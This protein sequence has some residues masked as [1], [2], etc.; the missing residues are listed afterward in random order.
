[1]PTAESQLALANASR[2]SGD[3]LLI[4]GF[5]DDVARVESLDDLSGLRCAEGQK[6]SAFRLIG[7]NDGAEFRAI[8][9]SIGIQDCV[10]KFVDE[11]G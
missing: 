11:R 10:S 5:D 8:E 4:V 7:E 1:M 6:T 9:R 3:R 2:I